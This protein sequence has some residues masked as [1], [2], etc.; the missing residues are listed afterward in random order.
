MKKIILI[1]AALCGLLLS[2]A[3]IFAAVGTAFTYQGLLN[4]SDSPATGIYEFRFRLYATDTDFT[5]LAA[6]RTNNNVPVT[7]GLFMTKIDFGDVF[8]GDVRWL[9]IGSRTNGSPSDFTPLNPR[10]ELTPTPYAMFATTAGLAN[11]IAPNSVTAGGLASNAV[12]TASIANGTVVRSLNGLTDTV[13]LSEGANVSFTTNGNTLQISASGGATSGWALGGN[14]GTTS[15]NFVG[16]T[17]NQPLELRVNNAS[18]IKARA[19]RLVATADSPQVIGGPS[20][21]TVAAG[22]QGATIAGGGSIATYGSPFPNQIFA[23]HGTIGGGLGNTISADAYES[24]IAGGNQN[25]IAPGAFRSTIGGGILN[26]ISNG[27]ATISGGS[28][29]VAGYEGATVGGGAGNIATG[30]YSTVGGGS[31]S[32][33]LNDYA[34]V[35][36]GHENQAS[37]SQ[38]TVTGG[39]GN[40][41]SGIGSAVGGGSGNTAS[42]DYG[43]VGGG[44][45]NTALATHAVIAGG[46]FNVN[47]GGASAIGG[48]QLNNVAVGAVNAVIGGGYNN[49]IHAN[50]VAATI[51]G[52]TDNTADGFGSFAAGVNAHANDNGSFVCKR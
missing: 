40:L 14:G 25:K 4:E 35:A 5:D 50:A 45:G 3:P 23:Y 15:A 8:H 37:G 34:T 29:N 47:S 33:A 12:I 32:L 10:E 51:P 18:G 28:Q 13:R 6:W 2:V 21:N 9:D 22:M 43:T 24:T 48:G 38:S 20:V 17:D 52:G 30:Y 42:A 27:T 31:G 46:H 1:P 41:A 44:Q 49:H 11:S 26:T 19:L 36:G 39:S 7:N 16:T